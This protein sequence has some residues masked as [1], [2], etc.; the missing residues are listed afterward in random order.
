MEKNENKIRVGA[1][2]II[3]ENKSMKNTERGE[4]R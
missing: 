4:K 3:M 2:E 1:M